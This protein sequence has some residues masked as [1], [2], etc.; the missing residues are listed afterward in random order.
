[1]EEKETPPVETGDETTPPEVIS[2]SY[3]NQPDYPEYNQDLIDTNYAGEERRNIDLRPQTRLDIVDVVL[4]ETVTRINQGEE[5]KPLRGLSERVDNIIK[6]ATASET[7]EY[8]F[9]I[10]TLPY[11]QVNARMLMSKG[12]VPTIRLHSKD[13]YGTPV[14]PIDE[15]KIEVESL[16]KKAFISLV[17]CPKYFRACNFIP[18]LDVEDVKKAADEERL[19]F[20]HEFSHTTHLAVATMENDKWDGHIIIPNTTYECYPLEQIKQYGTGLFE[21]IG[22][23]KTVDGEVAIFRLD[24]HIRR[25][26][27]G[28]KIYDMFPVLKNEEDEAKRFEK[29]KDLYTKMVMDMIGANWQYIPDYGKG[30]LYIRP[31]FFDHGEKMH[32][33]NSGKFM[34]TVTAV[35]IGSYFKPGEKVFFMA[36]KRSRTVEHSHEGMAKAVGHYA[37]PVRLLHKA[38]N[39]GM[40]GV[41]YTNRKGNRIEETPAS[42]VLFILTMKDGTRKIITPSLRH[43]TILDSITRKT[44]LTLAENE[45]GW[46]TEERQINPLEILLYSIAAK[47][48]NQVKAI[49][50]LMDKTTKIDEVK[51]MLL[52]GGMASEEID[53][54]TPTLQKLVKNIATKTED[55]IKNAKKEDLERGKIKKEYLEIAKN[56]ESIEAVAAG[57]AAALTSIHQIQMGEADQ[58]TDNPEKY[59]ELIVF[60]HKH[61]GE[62]GPASKKLFDLLLAVKSKKFQKELREKLT[63]ATPEDRPKLE[64]KLKEYE[65]WLTLVPPPQESTAQTA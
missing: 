20:T 54:I 30:R 2:Q 31:C 52:K 32:A 41:I 57:T 64:E 3:I 1:M 27:E 24:E 46:Q 22:V 12:L 59:Q 7:K 16:P 21:G 5:Y 58:E 14:W 35:P 18:P 4:K 45:L 37:R 11:F 19:K 36:L 63:D 17:K 28:G 6:T 49:E 15:K 38:K 53:K 48:P 60:D 34:M 55:N 25:M 10:D 23:E 51:E 43:G 13:R 47:D 44:S 39:K 42:S 33:D 50:M 40:E 29:F 62:M 56:I 9:S 26:Y 61:T 8:Y 65:S